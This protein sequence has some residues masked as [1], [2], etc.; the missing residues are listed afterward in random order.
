ML[1]LFS[2]LSVSFLF[3][4]FPPSLFLVTVATKPVESMR[5]RR[6]QLV[7]SAGTVD[8]FDGRVVNVLSVFTKGEITAAS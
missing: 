5:C 6:R 8:A 3:V 4:C 7:L 2:F 1:F